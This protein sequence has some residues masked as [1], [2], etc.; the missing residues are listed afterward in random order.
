[1]RTLIILSTLFLVF[2]SYAQSLDSLGIDNRPILNNYEVKLLNSLLEEQRD[3]FDFKNK[4]VAFITGSSGTKIISKSEYFNNSVI[5]WIE[6]DSSPQISMYQLT[7][8]EKSKSGGYDILVLSWEKLFTDKRRKK[9]VEILEGGIKAS[10][11]SSK[12]GEFHP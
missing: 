12:R 10:C 7:Y 4:K 11:Q 2:G 5:P 3:T 9:T 6:K 1:M 8:E